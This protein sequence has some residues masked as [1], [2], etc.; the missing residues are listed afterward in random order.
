M[1]DVYSHFFKI[2]T[3]NELAGIHCLPGFPTVPGSN[4][5]PEGIRWCQ[6]EWRGWEPCIFDQPPDVVIVRKIVFRTDY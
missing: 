2:N 4:A 5:C 3:R 1:V 6:R